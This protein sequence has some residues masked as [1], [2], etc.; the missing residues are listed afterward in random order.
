VEALVPEGGPD[1]LLALAG[2]GVGQADHVEPGQASGQVDL[3]LDGQGLDAMGRGG[4][5]VGQHREAG[6]RVRVGK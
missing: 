1:S 3:D 6:A 5:A 4:E 2:G